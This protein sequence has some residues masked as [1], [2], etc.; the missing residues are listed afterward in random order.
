MHRRQHD[1]PCQLDDD[2]DEEGAQP[3]AAEVEEEATNPEPSGSI[4]VW[5]N[6][7]EYGASKEALIGMGL[8]GR[9]AMMGPRDAQVNAWWTFKPKDCELLLLVSSPFR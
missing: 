4:T 1:E 5:A 6:L 2:D 8:R 3:C 9:W 7:D